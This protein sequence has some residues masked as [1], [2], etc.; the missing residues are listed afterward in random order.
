MVQHACLKTY[1]SSFL[2]FFNL[3][4]KWGRR[5]TGIHLSSY[6]I[7]PW[8]HTHTCI[9]ICVCVYIYIISN[10]AW[11]DISS[12]KITSK[13]KQAKYLK[14]NRPELK[15]VWTE[16]L[17]ILNFNRRYSKNSKQEERYF[18]KVI[19]WK[20]FFKKVYLNRLYPSSTQ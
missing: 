19:C 2:F 9:Y 10:W 4:R 11:R 1:M 13:Q 7:L 12:N 6:C 5:K 17:K 14:Q 3:N 18:C 20:A 16:G 15:D 8:G